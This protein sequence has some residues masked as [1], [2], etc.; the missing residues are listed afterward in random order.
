MR[1]LFL[2]LEKRV[3]YIAKFF[4]YEGITDYL[5]MRFRDSLTPIFEDVKNKGGIRDYYIIC[6]QR[7]NNANT[8]D[9][10]ELHCTIAV[11]PVKSLEFILLSFVCTNQS[12]NVQEVAESEL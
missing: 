1:R 12:A 10:N 9:N 2:G 11:R 3:R 8:I 6:D 5:M 4:K 7:N